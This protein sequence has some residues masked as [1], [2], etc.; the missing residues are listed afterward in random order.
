MSRAVPAWEQCYKKQD[1]RHAAYVPF[2][3]MNENV[4]P[5][6]HRSFASRTRAAAAARFVSSKPCTGVTVS[7]VAVPDVCVPSAG[8][9]AAARVSAAVRSLF[10]LDSLAEER[11]TKARKKEKT[12]SI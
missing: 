7:E 6:N 12:R 9:C 2:C 5:A 8:D 1:T 11:G 10:A 4:P 3:P